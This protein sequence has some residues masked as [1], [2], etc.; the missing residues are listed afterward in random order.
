MAETKGRKNIKKEFICGLE[1]EKE[2]I[3][4]LEDKKEYK[5]KCCGKEYNTRIVYNEE[6]GG[7]LWQAV[8]VSEGRIN[9]LS[10]FPNRKDALRNIDLFICAQN[11]RVEDVKAKIGD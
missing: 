8:V 3:T 7:L 5:I 4:D 2:L 10:F 6:R 1:L 11:G 9:S